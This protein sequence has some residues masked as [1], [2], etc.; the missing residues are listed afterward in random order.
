MS[1]Y[2]LVL[3]LVHSAK[4]K[5]RTDEVFFFFCGMLTEGAAAGRLFWSP[6][7]STLAHSS[8]ASSGCTSSM[9][10]VCAVVLPCVLC[11]LSRRLLLVHV[12]RTKRVLDGRGPEPV[13]ATGWKWALLLDGWS[14][15]EEE[16]L[17]DIGTNDLVVG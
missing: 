15:V 3:V 13:D 16:A 1:R 12:R 5:T 4:T 6:L 10:R 8:I 9:G 7:S 17:F 14:V 2:I 11:W